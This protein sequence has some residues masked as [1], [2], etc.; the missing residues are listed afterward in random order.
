MS[1]NKR[2]EARKGAVWHALPS[3]RLGATTE[4]DLGDA[5]G[6][7]G[8]EGKHPFQDRSQ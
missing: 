4:K 7:Q 3:N 1:E 6:S 5:P 8:S 2:P